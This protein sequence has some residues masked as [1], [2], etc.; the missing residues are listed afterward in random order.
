MYILICI[1]GFLAG[2]FMFVVDIALS[3]WFGLFGTYTIYKQWL[4][5]AGLFKGIEDIAMFIGHQINAIIFGI[6]LVHPI[7]YKKLPQNTILKGLVFSILWHVTVLIVSFFLSIGG[8]KWMIDL[9]NMSV[10]AYI[11]LLLLHIIW[12]VSLTVFYSPKK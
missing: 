12:G 11:S 4:I 3:G 10:K 6:F 9:I 5:E 1:A 7:I 8:A 2:Y